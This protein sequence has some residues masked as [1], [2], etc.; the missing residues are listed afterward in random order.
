MG[1]SDYAAPHAAAA[2]EN[3]DVCLSERGEKGR[4][5]GLGLKVVPRLRELCRQGQ[6]GMISNSSNKVHQ[7]WDLP[8]SRVLYTGV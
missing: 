3:A 6:A 5:T 8:F 4:D 1:D 7:T 2:E